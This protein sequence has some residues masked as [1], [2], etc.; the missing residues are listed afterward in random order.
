MFDQIFLSPQLKQSMNI[1]DKH[2]IKE[3]PNE[4]KTQDFKKSGNSREYQEN[5]KTS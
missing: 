2:G 3:L 1:S 4:L 5:L